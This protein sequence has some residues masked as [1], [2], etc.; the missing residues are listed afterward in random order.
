MWLWRG[1]PVCIL[2]FDNSLSLM[3]IPVL[4]ILGLGAGRGFCLLVCCAIL[5]ISFLELL[6]L[7]FQHSQLTCLRPYYRIRWQ[8]GARNVFPSPR[9]KPYEQQDR[10]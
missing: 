2:F 8:R 6:T 4:Q 9:H 1:E 10:P 5:F 3:D 7:F